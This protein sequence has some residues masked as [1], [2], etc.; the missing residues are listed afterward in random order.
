MASNSDAVSN[1][2]PKRTG[3]KEVE[4]EGPLSL[5]SANKRINSLLR[6]IRS[7]LKST[8][9]KPDKDK[10]NS[11][12][13]RLTQISH[14]HGLTSKQASQVLRLASGLDSNLASNQEDQGDS[15]DEPKIKINTSTS[16]KLIKLIL[17]RPGEKFNR[18]F[19]LLI[20]GNLSS[21]PG[22]LEDAPGGQDHLREG[23]KARR[24]LDLK[25]QVSN[26]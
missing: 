19:V 24:K 15:D 20:L 26:R 4:A 21:P 25:V 23:L 11:K 16:I 2:N 6:S 22:V 8:I 5:S 9:Q 14:S 3:Q 7:L 13:E 1:D 10:L 18:D 12:I 17:P